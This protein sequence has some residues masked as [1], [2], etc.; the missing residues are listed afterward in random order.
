[1]I[2]KTCEL[3]IKYDVLKDYNLLLD[4]YNKIHEKNLNYK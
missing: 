3:K 2:D 4:E 1:M